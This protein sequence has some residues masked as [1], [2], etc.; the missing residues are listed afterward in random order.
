MSGVDLLPLPLS[1][2]LL[3]RY[4][5]AS[6]RQRRAGMVGG[7]QMR[8]KGQSLDFRDYE[9]YTPGDD[10]R[11]V[12][13]RAS[14]R[15]GQVED[16]LVRHYTAEEQLSLVISVDTRPSM[17]LPEAMPKMQI[18]AWLAEAVA[19]VALDSEDRV[20]MHRLFGEAGGGLDQLRG[21]GSRGRVRKILRRFV[22]YRGSVAF[23]KKPL[24]RCLAPTSVWII[25]TDL[26]F[27][28]NDQSRMLAREIA[29]AQE[30][31]CWVILV[32]LDSW[33]HERAYL[34]HGA[35]RIEG[36]GLSPTRNRFE[37]SDENLAQVETR[38]RRHKQH[39]FELIRRAS[40]D[41]VSW[42]WPAEVVPAPVEFFKARFLGDKVLQR[43]FMKDA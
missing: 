35:R 15:Y 25:L 32:D 19:D 2:G 10:I 28:S 39:F 8:R 34:G 42:H 3:G 22:D 16:L 30:G 11:H 14:A 17:A 24:I 40:C 6:R 18:A 21:S 4:R 27:D 37:V 13:W 38:I 23:N 36:P 9:H 29:R 43:L 12:D 5:T 41:R 31:L 20:F 33:P 1:R 7:H 26:Y